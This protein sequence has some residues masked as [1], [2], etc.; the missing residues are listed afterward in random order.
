MSSRVGSGIAGK[1]IASVRRMRRVSTVDLML[2]GTVILWAL[3]ITVTRYVLTHGW[4]PLAYGTI[5]YFAATALFWVFTFHRERTMR[6]RISDAKLV[7]LAAGMLFLN[8]LA[9]VY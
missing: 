1:A 9:F 8:Q 6:V 2:L 4:K 3:N 5:R 7:G